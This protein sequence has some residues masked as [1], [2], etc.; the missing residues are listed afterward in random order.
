LQQVERAGRA[1]QVCSTRHSVSSSLLQQ[2]GAGQLH[3]VEE[4]TKNQQQLFIAKFGELL[5]RFVWK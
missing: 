4:R 2:K 3:F 1:R 5:A